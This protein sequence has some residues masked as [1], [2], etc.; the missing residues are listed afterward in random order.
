MAKATI[1]PAVHAERNALA[2]DLAGI[3]EGGWSTTSLCSDWSVRDVIAHM[4]ASARITPATFF[5]KLIGSGFSLTRMQ[6][7]D[8]AANRGDSPG[9]TL[10]RFEAV[11]TSETGPPGPPETMLGETLVHANDVRRALGIAHDYP[12]EAVMRVAD[13]YKGSNLI[14]GGKRRVAGVCLR[15]T[16]TGWAHGSGPEVSGPIMALVMAMTGRKAVLS[17]LV[18]DGVAVLRQRS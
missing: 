14:I 6:K 5:P 11:I 17:E 13:F 7:K 3:G 15:A 2:A 18:G 10:R 12:T 16:D 9:D 1:W 8:I 4:T